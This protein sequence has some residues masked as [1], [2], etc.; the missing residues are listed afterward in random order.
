M[1]KLLPLFERSGTHVMFTGHEHNFQHSRVPG[2]DH[3]VTGAAGKVRRARPDR[4]APAHTASWA[5]E[6]HF[7][8]ARIEGKRMTVRAIGAIDDPEDT[9][10]DIERFDPQGAPLSGPIEIKL[11]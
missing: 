6:C 1:E 4:F 7:L 9:P 10:R 8:L 11:N 5:E 2:F 3:F